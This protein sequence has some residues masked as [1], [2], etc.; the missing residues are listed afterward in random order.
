MT[1]AYAVDGTRLGWCSPWWRRVLIGSCW[2]A[3]VLRGRWRARL[4]AVDQFETRLVWGYLPGGGVLQHPEAAEVDP[5]PL[6]L[7]TVGA[8]LAPLA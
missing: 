7:R 8:L 5:E 4:G 6:T 2:A 1:W 3:D